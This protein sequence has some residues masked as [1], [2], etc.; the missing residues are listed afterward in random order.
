MGMRKIIPFFLL[1][2]KPGCVTGEEYLEIYSECDKIAPYPNAQRMAHGLNAKTMEP[3]SKNRSN[4]QY[5]APVPL[6]RI[7][8]GLCSIQTIDQ[9]R[10]I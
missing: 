2:L 1:M 9:S 8:F 7:F 3:S 5:K 6:S 10:T 4:I